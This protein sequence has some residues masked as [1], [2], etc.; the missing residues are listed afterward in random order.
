MIVTI[1]A[2]VAIAA[3]AAGSVAVVTRDGLSRI[4]TRH[5]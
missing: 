5:L 1:T 3:G 2:L 4:P